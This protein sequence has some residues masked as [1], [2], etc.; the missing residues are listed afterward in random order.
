[1]NYELVIIMVTI[2][3]GWVSLGGF[4]WAIHR[5]IVSLRERMSG[6]EVKLSERMARLEGSMDVLKDLFQASI[7]V[8]S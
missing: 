7:T 2:I 8:K 1:M 6:L 3:T 5:D 4:L